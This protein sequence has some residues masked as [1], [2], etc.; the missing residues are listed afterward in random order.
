M[1]TN[2]LTPSVEVAF[3]KLKELFSHDQS[4]SFVFHLIKA[5]G[6]NQGV[7][8]THILYGVSSALTYKKGIG[9][10]SIEQ[11]KDDTLRRKL[12]SFLTDIRVSKDSAVLEFTSKFG[13]TEHDTTWTTQMYKSMNSKKLL[14]RSEYI[15]LQQF[16][17]FLNE[18]EVEKKEV[19]EIFS[20]HVT[21]TVNVLELAETAKT[22]KKTSKK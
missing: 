8:S 6:K 19:K 13:W 1:N 15:A 18:Q 10:K 2:N 7:P 17:K 5:F 11:V 16:E 21:D 3:A 14:T 4:R 22:N 9:P 12:A 20:G